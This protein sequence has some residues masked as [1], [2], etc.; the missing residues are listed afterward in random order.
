[1][2]ALGLG[3][4]Q[5]LGKCFGLHRAVGGRQQ[6]EDHLAAGDGLL[7]AGGLAVGI[8]IRRATILAAHGF[9][10]QRGQRWLVGAARRRLGEPAGLLARRLA[11]WFAATGAGRAATLAGGG[12]VGGAG[13]A[14]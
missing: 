11:T 14:G 13:L 2:E 5:P 10:V 7:V 1:I 9:A 8:R 6:L 4:P 12:G 3:Q